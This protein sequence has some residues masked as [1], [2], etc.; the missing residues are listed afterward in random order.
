MIDLTTGLRSISQELIANLSRSL[1][2][3]QIGIRTEI[4]LND[5]EARIEGP[6]L[7]LL[8]VQIV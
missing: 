8:T 1:T 4:L 5:H 2:S 3:L 6:F 7:R